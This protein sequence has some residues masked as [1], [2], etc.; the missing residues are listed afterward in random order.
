MNTFH[1]ESNHSYKFSPKNNQRTIDFKIFLLSILITATFYV[2]PLGRVESFGTDYRLFDFAFGVFFILIGISEWPKIIKIFKER[3]KVFWW[4]SI[5]IL[6]VWASLI[7]T[8]ITGG[9]PKAFPAI[10]RSI[11][12]TAHFFTGA[13]VVAL[14]DSPS[15][16]RRILN[17]FY[18]NILIQ[19]GL[20]IAQKLGWLGTFW[21]SYYV[22]SYGELPVGTLS[23][24]HKHIGI[25]MLLGI[26]ICLTFIKVK[27]DIFSKFIA[28]FSMGLM[29]A[30]SIFALSRTGWLG[31]AGMALGYFYIYRRQSIGT[32]LI[33]IIGLLL[34]LLILQWVGIDLLTLAKE[35]L[36]LVVFD[37]YERFGIE[38]ITGD[39]MQ[40]YDN[41]PDAIAAAPW[42]LITGTG[43][44]NIITY[45]RAAGAHNNYI[46]VL[47]ELG[48]FGFIVY[49]GMLRQILR[50][51]Q[52]AGKV[53]SNL[54]ENAYAKSTFAV[55]VGILFTMLVGESF[56]GQTSMQTMTAQI[57]IMIGLAIAPL[58]HWHNDAPS[59][60]DPGHMADNQ[61]AE[62]TT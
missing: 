49:M 13:C 38:G 15:K 18:I 16:Y 52:N 35:D 59:E 51:L 57:M 54:L 7:V 20:A 30:A 42:I 22:S 50:E 11:R 27:K 48:V 9:A 45:I 32:A 53:L 56:W 40:V 62:K 6:L 58:Y 21:P 34:S 43:F 12:F 61:S 17:V 44:Q 24:H 47:F 10:I 36:D 2:V 37:R 25:V 8:F 19:A 60:S 26:G 33:I 5:L 3:K 29:V 14:V 41:F 39:R 4:A 23:A 1:Q 31:L 46:Q 28:I 55:F